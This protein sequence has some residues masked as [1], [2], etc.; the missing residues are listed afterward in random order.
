M[1]NPLNGKK[2]P[3][4]TAAYVRQLRTVRRNARAA[5]RSGNPARREPA[6]KVLRRVGPTIGAVYVQDVERRAREK[7]RRQ[8]MR[9]IEKAGVR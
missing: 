1:K 5:A 3:K 6:R 9:N 7:A 4:D 2:M 8:L